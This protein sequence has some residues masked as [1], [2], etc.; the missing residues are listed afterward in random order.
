[1]PLTGGGGVAGGVVVEVC[2]GVL[3]GVASAGSTWAGWCLAEY[4]RRGFVQL[5]NDHHK[6]K[7]TVKCLQWQVYKSGSSQNSTTGTN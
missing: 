2:L 5:K 6:N 1:V 3:D 7:C 4:T